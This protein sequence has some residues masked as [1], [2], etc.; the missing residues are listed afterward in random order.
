M[1]KTTTFLVAGT[2]SITALFWGAGAIADDSQKL[3]GD[4]EPG[5]SWKE[6]PYDFK[7]GN[8]LDTH[9]QVSLKT[10]KGQPKS[11][12]GALYVYFTGKIDGASRL[13]IARH[14]RGESHIETCG[15]GPITCVVGWTLSGRP[16]A[17]KFLY[18]SGVNGNDHPVW[19]VNRAEEPEPAVPGMVIPQPGYYSHYHW[20]TTTS[21]DP[22]AS[23]PD[24]FP[25]ACDKSSAGALEDNA[26]S[27]VNEICEGWFLQIKATQSFAFQHGGEIIPIHK[28]SDIRSHL[29]IVTNYTQFPW[30]PIE[31][32]RPTG[33]N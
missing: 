2:A 10:K 23:E 13:P 27:A 7:F 25:A 8:H 26:P 33:G 31:P 14:P 11:L 19:M 28:G 12:R 30:V 1:R 17:A 15:V 24:D 3:P 32:T 29:N 16:G 9:V 6:A 5:G 4:V 20:I 18:H 22:R 21:T